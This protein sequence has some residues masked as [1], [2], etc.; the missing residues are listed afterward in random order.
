MR[1]SGGGWLVVGVLMLVCCTF[2]IIVGSAFAL[3]A[4]RAYELVSPA[5]KGGY[6]VAG[7]EAL[8][9]GGES[10]VF[11]SQGPF[12][13]DPNY[14][15]LANYYLARRSALG[16][17]TVPLNPPATLLPDSAPGDFSAS[18]ESSLSAGRLGPSYSG[19]FYSSTEFD[20][21]LH[22]SGLPDTAL[23]FESLGAVKQVEPEPPIGVVYAGASP[24]FSHLVFYGQ[25]K[26]FLKEAGKT[27]SNLYDME[28]D[29]SGG[30]SSLRLVGVD[31][32]GK[33]KVFEPNCAPE[34]GVSYGRASSF[35]AVAA[36]GNE[37]FFTMGT[38]ADEAKG[39]CNGQLFVRVDGS[40]TVE[41]SRPASSKCSEVPCVSETPSPVER[42]PAEFQGASEDG[43]KVF[44]TT[45]QPLVAEEKD[46]GQDLY[47]ARIGCGHG[48]DECEGAKKEVTSLT[49]VSAGSEAAEVQGVVTVAA[50]GSR[51]YF[52]AR[53]VLG[54]G[55]NPEG[56]L[57][58]KGADNLYVYDDG[59]AGSQPIYIGDLC[60]GNGFSGEARDL[61]CPDTEEAKDQ[62]LWL[63]SKHE[64]Q[65]NGCESVSLSCE[66]G[67]F[68]VFST[69]A[70][71]TRDDTNEAKDVYRYDAV[72]G[73]LLRVSVGED[74]YDADGNGETCRNGDCNASIGENQEI[75]FVFRER[76]LNSRAVSSDGSRVVFRTAEPLS[77]DATNG[78]E[79]AYE[80]QSAEDGESGAV[81]LI[82]TGNSDEP[83]NQVVISQTGG[84][85]LFKTS[86][87][88][89][90]QDTDGLADI[91][92]ARLNGGFPPRVVEERACEGE[93]CYGPLT[94]PAPLLVPGSVEQQP[95][96]N[97]SV[98]T[99]KPA[100]KTKKHKV[101]R[102]SR[103]KKLAARRPGK[104]RKTAG[105]GRR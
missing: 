41:L 39:E 21:L 69:Y 92:D 79:N 14:E 63:S 99:S 22:P 78:L 17:S 19:A 51:I 48:E 12:D 102:T 10:V 47:L 23:G 18:L 20:F 44:F 56:R 95:G 70:R 98:P 88:L 3:P 34:L 27:S 76:D 85:V 26:P 59:V 6:G 50:D 101:K 105:R 67:R 30:A 7:I 77:E 68:L 71:L 97:Y 55:A 57:P 96:G 93:A 13:G 43:S 4:G 31:D 65:T 33:N 89:V 5:Y 16:W 60:S 1:G 46:T 32:Q 37:I 86:Q 75:A 29:V 81:S 73:R 54:A 84:D 74:G 61:R 40:K 9:P 35:N 66:P 52:V 94:N 103:K 8:A 100:A 82:S 80:W 53:G 15:V 72:T 62:D 28:T 24:D 91:Y 104:A 25:G 58:V 64:A 38:A 49:R 83:V 45:A 90:S 2:S 42:L 11:S 87:G 36:D